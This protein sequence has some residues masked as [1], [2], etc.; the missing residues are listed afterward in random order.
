MHAPFGQKGTWWIYPIYVDNDQRCMRKDGR[1]TRPG[2]LR[3]ESI[4]CCCCCC[5]G[6]GAKS[7]IGRKSWQLF[8]GPCTV[9]GVDPT[10]L[11]RPAKWRRDGW[12]R[13][14]HS[15]LTD[16]SGTAAA[17][18]VCNAVYSA[19]VL[20][21]GRR[22]PLGLQIVDGRMIKVW[23]SSAT[24]SSIIRHSSRPRRLHQ[25]AACISFKNTTLLRLRRVDDWNC[26]RLI[27]QR[28]HTN[29]A[30][31]PVV[32]HVRYGVQ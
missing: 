28:K 11:P 25:P 8:G 26:S 1:K 2:M 18:F 19:V 27:S 7:A 5:C 17:T 29:N 24:A 30:I 21:T 14:P 12:E 20:R 32:I 22:P 31:I 15:R 10:T 16:R 4:V 6:C 13:R 3:L 9:W 23:A